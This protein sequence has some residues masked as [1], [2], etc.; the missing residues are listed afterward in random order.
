MRF[1][2]SYGKANEILGWKPT[3][4]LEEEL[5]KEIEWMRGETAH[6]IIRTICLTEEG[7]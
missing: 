4:S 7:T 2:G 3:T 1:I 5:K 6:K